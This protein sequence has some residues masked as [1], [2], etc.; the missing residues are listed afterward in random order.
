MP[1][2]VPS[3]AVYSCTY[4]SFMFD[5]KCRLINVLNLVYVISLVQ[6]RYKFGKCAYPGTGYRVLYWVLYRV[7]YT[8]TGYYTG[9]RV[10]YHM[11]A[12]RGVTLERASWKPKP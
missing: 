7:L 1:R 4:Y 12:Y 8:C 5:D 2:R 11:Y 9:Y 3:T 6:G 10:L